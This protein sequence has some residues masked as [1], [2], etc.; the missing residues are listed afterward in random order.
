MFIRVVDVQ[1]WVFISAEPLL[2]IANAQTQEGFF[3]SWLVD[4]IQEEVAV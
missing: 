4:E 2:K 3:A 1:Q